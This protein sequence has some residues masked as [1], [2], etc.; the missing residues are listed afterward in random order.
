MKI[1]KMKTRSDRVIRAGPSDRGHP[2]R[3]ACDGYGKKGEGLSA[4]QAGA[5]FIIQLVI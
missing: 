2:G 1:F 5:E 4:G 3:P